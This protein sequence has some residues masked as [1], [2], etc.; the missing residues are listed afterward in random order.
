MSD[1]PVV[2]STERLTLRVPEPAD[3]DRLFA[4]YSDERVWGPDPLSRHETP[5]QTARMIDNWRAAW[6]R[7]GLGMWTAWDDDDF[8]GIG[9]CMV[10]YG[11]AWNLG[12]RLSPARW[13]RGYAQEISAAG[14]AAARGKRA[15]LPVTAYLLEGNDRS[16][17][18][19]ERLGLHRVW[20]GPDAGNPDPTAIRLLYSD[21]PL[22]PRVLGALTDR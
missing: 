21:Q 20:R 7:D 4:L 13:G 8:V 1:E 5:A 3:L 15:E 14:I 11:V 10:R 22:P 6:V 18:S 19:V 2:H 12:F 17:R 9:G 16:L